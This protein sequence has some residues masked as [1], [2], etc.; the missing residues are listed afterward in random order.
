MR[1]GGGPV[2]AIVTLAPARGRLGTR[3]PKSTAAGWTKMPGATS[4]AEPSSRGARAA[5]GWAPER[6]YS[7]RA[8]GSDS[9]VNACWTSSK[10]AA[11][12][13]A[14]FTS[15]WY[16]RLSRRRACAICAP[17]ASRG[18]PSTAYGSKRSCTLHSSSPATGG[19]LSNQHP[20]RHAIASNAQGQHKGRLSFAKS[21]GD[22]RLAR[23]AD[24]T[25]VIHQLDSR[26]CTSCIEM[27][28]SSSARSPVTCR[29]LA[30]TSRDAFCP[31]AR[32]PCRPLRL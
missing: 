9:T 19:P 13:G 3:R 21:R 8:A 10:R 30:S 22:T 1:A 26:L 24:R 15:G 25:R 27:L 23:A 6:S 28:N 12:S 11:V 5:P 31:R 29:L 14:L 17:E 4:V 32:H 2:Q 20:A 16:W 18:T 7:A